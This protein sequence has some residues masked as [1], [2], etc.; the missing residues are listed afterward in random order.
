LREAKLTPKTAKRLELMLPPKQKAR[1][2][3]EGRSPARNNGRQSPS[4]K[5]AEAGCALYLLPKAKGCR[6]HP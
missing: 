2:K 6:F 5:G 1:I 3:L 4:L